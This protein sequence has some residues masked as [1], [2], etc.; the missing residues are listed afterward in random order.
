M[1]KTIRP[2]TLRRLVELTDL[3]RQEQHV[4][5]EDIRS[6]LDLSDRRTTEVLA[7]M[8]RL[9]LIQQGDAVRLTGTGDAFADAVQSEDWRGVHE[10]LYEQSPHYRAFID[11]LER[12]RATQGLSDDE[13]AQELD[14]CSADLRFN[15]TSVALLTDWGE[16]L[17]AVQR[18]VFTDRYYS[19]LTERDDDPFTQILQEEY[20]ALEVNRGVNLRQRYLSIPRLRERICE[21]LRIPRDTFNNRLI[22]VCEANI[23]NLELSGAPLNTQ[24]KESR[25]GIKTI[26]TNEQGEVV[27]TEMDSDSVLSGVRLTDGKT[28]YYLAIFEQLMDGES[29]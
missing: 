28:Y 21:R 26:R 10:I 3:C 4:T 29:E 16:R 27:T 2:I 24:A 12:H 17:R 15:A 22:V 18:N 14:H 11:C 25:R 13:L 5:T 7:E 1:R 9:S 23:G 8:D 20:E 6:M 19:V